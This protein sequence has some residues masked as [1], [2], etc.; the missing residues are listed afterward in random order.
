MKKYI[1]PLFICF[2]IGASCSKKDNPIPAKTTGTYTFQ[3]VY[4]NAPQPLA[5]LFIWKA[6]NKDFEIKSDISSG[7]AFD[8]TSQTSIKYDY[9]VSNPTILSNDL[10]AGRYFIYI[11]TGSDAFPRGMYS[12]TYFTITAGQTTVLKKIFRDQNNFAYESW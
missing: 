10:P 11:V 6:D 1:L 12:Y 7:Y 9:A 8:K 5:F 4:N 3:C 2:F